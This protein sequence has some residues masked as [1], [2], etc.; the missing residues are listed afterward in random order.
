MNQT[1]NLQCPELRGTLSA[2]CNLPSPVLITGIGGFI[3][4]HLAERLLAA[5]V[6]VRGTARRPEAVGWLAARGV[7]VVPA[8]L[9]DVASLRRAVVGCRTVVHAAAWTGGAD[10]VS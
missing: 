3:A 8:D 4:S 2:I 5:G 10:G 9:M 6:A 1:S 7:E